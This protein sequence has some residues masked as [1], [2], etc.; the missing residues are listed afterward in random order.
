MSKSLE[1]TIDLGDLGH[2]EA[3]IEY[4]FEKGERG[5]RHEPAVEPSFWLET[6]KVKGTDLLPLIADDPLI[7]REVTKQVVDAYMESMQ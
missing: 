7:L 6:I 5:S 3:V 1:M 4:D 2:K